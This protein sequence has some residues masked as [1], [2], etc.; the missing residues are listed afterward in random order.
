MFHLMTSR[1][2]VDRDI[3]TA[4]SFVADVANRHLQCRT[5]P[6]RDSFAVPVK[7]WLAI[8]SDLKRLTPTPTMPF[9]GNY[10]R[11]G[12]SEAQ[13]IRQE[14]LAIILNTSPARRQSVIDSFFP[15]N[16]GMG[17]MLQTSGF[18]LSVLELF[19]DLRGSRQTGGT[20]QSHVITYR[21]NPS[22]GFA[23]YSTA[24][25]KSLENTILAEIPTRRPVVIE[26]EK[27]VFD[28]RLW[29]RLTDKA[30]RTFTFL[31]MKVG[32]VAVFTGNGASI[33]SDVEYF[34]MDF[35]VYD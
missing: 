18:G 30:S 12:E 27:V 11:E 15:G 20:W 32:M 14:V 10:G 16:N 8:D 4:E 31:L 9:V 13:P 2:H 7:P 5:N 24:T 3:A 22:V 35:V 6:D 25:T 29:G 34:P 33:S 19:D 17:V 26:G 21:G 23:L 1:D 28:Y